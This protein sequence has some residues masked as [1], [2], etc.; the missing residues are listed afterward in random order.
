MVFLVE[1]KDKRANNTQLV[2]G[3]T[4]GIRIKGFNDREQGIQIEKV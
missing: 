2:L 4:A 1:H 3:G